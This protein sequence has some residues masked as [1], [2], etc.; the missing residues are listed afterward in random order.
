MIKINNV[1]LNPGHFPDGTLAL[2][3]PVFHFG[4]NEIDIEWHYENDSE[5]FTIYCLRKHYSDKEV[6]LTMPYI[7]NARM[8]RVKS[9]MEV[10]TLKHFCEFINSLKFK[11]VRVLDAH[12]NVSLALL[13]NVISCSVMDHIKDA[14]EHFDSIHGSENVLIFYPDEGAMKRYSDN[15]HPPRPYA[16]GIKK[17]NWA[18][19]AILKLDI[20]NKEIVK[21]KHVLIIDDICSKG[22]TF[23]YSALALLEAGAASVSLY[24]THC[25]NA[26]LDGMI[27]NSE[28]IDY[29]YTTDSLVHRATLKKK[30]IYV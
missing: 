27:F 11:E 30:L 6:T 24:I 3:A 8:D 22:T 5:L 20:F 13:D 29:V 12:S 4:E 28:L 21:D 18:D 14:I 2:K 19:G 23:Y 9:D 1:E 15:M 10:F 25:E 17:R 26:I 16:F 7:P